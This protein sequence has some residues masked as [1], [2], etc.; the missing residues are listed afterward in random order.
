[1][2][3][4]QGTLTPLLGIGVCVSIQFGALEHTKRYFASK[5]LAS[6]IGGENGALLT[7]PQ[8][9]TAGVAAGLANGFVSGPVEHIRIRKYYFKII[10]FV[11][12]GIW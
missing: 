3:P 4:S 10:I 8:L 5:N 12:G 7:A 1:L 9:L 6:G 2:L 11:V